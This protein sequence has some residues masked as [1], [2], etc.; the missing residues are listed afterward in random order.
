[1]ASPFKLN[2]VGDWEAQMGA[3]KTL[4]ISTS[5]NSGHHRAVVRNP[6][7]CKVT[8]AGMELPDTNYDTFSSV[9]STF[10]LKPILK[11]VT[12]TLGGNYGL[13]MTLEGEIQRRGFL[14]SVLVKI[15]FPESY[16]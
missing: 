11:S 8:G 4:W 2:P 6:A 16:P 10:R 12:L 14:D 7:F 9:Y 3:R 13:T 5:P 1:M 15:I